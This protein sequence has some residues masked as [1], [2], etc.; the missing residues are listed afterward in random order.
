MITGF[1]MTAKITKLLLFLLIIGIFGILFYFISAVNLER[2]TKIEGLGTNLVEQEKL[3]ETDVPTT[4]ETVVIS[5]P[6][7]TLSSNLLQPGDTLV[8]KINDPTFTGTII[9]ELGSTKTDFVKLMPDG[10]WVGIFGIAPKTI[11]GKRNLIINYSNGKK[12]EKELTIISRKFP[13]TKLVVTKEL[14]DKG[15]TPA[16]IQDNVV[17][18]ENILLGSVLN[19]YTQQ[20]YFDKAFRNPLSRIENVGAFGNIRQNGNVSLQHLGVDLDAVMGTPIYAINSGI[21]SFEKELTNYGKTIIIDH[22]LGIFSL[23]LHLSEFK[24]LNG[25]TVQLGDIIGLTGNT[26]YSIAPHLHF[27]V[28]INGAS[29]DPLKFIDTIKQEL[30]N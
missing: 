16:I 25:E 5:L 23:Y 8:V 20:A 4:K 2:K 26:G 12:I 11:S 6:I 22:G 27:S 19:T 10:E 3:D 30:P 21:I 14:E 9:G 28:K 18:K 15:F 13:V 24:K 1:K 17:N 29:A 7:I